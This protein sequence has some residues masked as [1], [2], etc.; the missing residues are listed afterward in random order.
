MSNTTDSQQAVE[1]LAEYLIGR[2]WPSLRGTRQWHG[3]RYEYQCRAAAIL[4]G[5]AWAIRTT[6]P[7]A[8]SEIQTRSAWATL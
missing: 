6:W 2:D 4:A 1:A 3:K 5:E 8:A 7:E